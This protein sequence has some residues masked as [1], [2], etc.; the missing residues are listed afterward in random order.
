[1]LILRSLSILK[2]WTKYANEKCVQYVNYKM[3]KDQAVDKCNKMGGE[4]L[5]IHSQ[6]EQDFIT[7]FTALNPEPYIGITRKSSSYM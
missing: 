7:A 5:S 6:D 4:I 2:G 3:T 1:M